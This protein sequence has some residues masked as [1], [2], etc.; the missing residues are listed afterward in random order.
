VV[1]RRTR[2][3]LFLHKPLFDRRVDET[4]VGGR[5]VN[6]VPRRLLLMAL[7]GASPALVA[8]GHVHQYRITQ[9]A[10]ATHVWGTSTAYVIPDR[11]QPRYGPK[12][13]GYVEHRLHA[14]G[15]HDS[16]LV[17]VPGV[18]TLDIADFPEAY[19]PI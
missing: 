16:E 13:V 12:E 15:R 6:P 7:R 8:C 18:P 11:R 5:F 3:A 10:G 17:R 1:L 2:L 19:G 9:P 14:D 4:E